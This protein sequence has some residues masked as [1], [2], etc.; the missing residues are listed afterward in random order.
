MTHWR[1]HRQRFCR[2]FGLPCGRRQR[3]L[4]AYI[5]RLRRVAAFSY[6]RLTYLTLLQLLRQT[7]LTSTAPALGLTTAGLITLNGRRCL[8][9]LTQL[10]AQDFVL[11]SGAGGGW[12]SSQAILAAG[13]AVSYDTPAYL[14]VDELCNG[15][16]ILFEPQVGAQAAFTVG[17]PTLP[18]LTVKCYNWKYLT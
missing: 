5:V 14:E 15:F 12:C 8:N 9:P 16:V 2:G 7:Y 13:G 11:L 17:Q 4:T 3:R 6:F 18:F 10:Y 1:H